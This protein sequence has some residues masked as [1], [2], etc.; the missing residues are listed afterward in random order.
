MLITVVFL[1]MCKLKQL[2]SGMWPLKRTVRSSSNNKF[3][4][5][6]TLIWTGCRMAALL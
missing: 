5:F 6:R 1:T 4:E 3:P 2:K